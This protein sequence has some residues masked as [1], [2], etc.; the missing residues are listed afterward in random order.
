MRR[1][2]NGYET[3]MAAGE[4]WRVARPVFLGERAPS[5]TIRYD[6]GLAGW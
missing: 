5:A 4:S 6:D 3:R 2:A 1:G